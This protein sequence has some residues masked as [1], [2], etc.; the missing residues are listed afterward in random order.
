MSD[1]KDDRRAR[2]AACLA[3]GWV[4]LGDARLL[5]SDFASASGALLAPLPISILPG[6]GVLDDVRQ[7][8]IMRLAAVEIEWDHGMLTDEDYHA[9]KKEIVAEVTELFRDTLGRTLGLES[10]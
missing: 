2:W 6:L 7:T 3:R 10:A 4:S 1:Q 9:R 8:L 5:D